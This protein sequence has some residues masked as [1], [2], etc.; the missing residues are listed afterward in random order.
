MRA[1]SAYSTL[2]HKRWRRFSDTAKIRNPKMSFEDHQF[3]KGRAKTGGRK[4]GV[5][6]RLSERFVRD[7]QR[8]WQRSG[9]ATLK[10]LAKENPEALA[11]LA[12]SLVPREW[13]GEGLATIIVNTGVPRGPG[14]ASEVAHQAR[15]L[16]EPKI[17]AITKAEPE[18]VKKL[19]PV[20]VFRPEGFEDGTIVEYP[21]AKRA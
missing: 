8:E 9:E 15:K 13:T 10:I 1:A 7:L 2:R 12:S 3:Q 19:E 18:P 17:P 14:F 5:R 4:P 20:R 6:N 16:P 11:K 21:P